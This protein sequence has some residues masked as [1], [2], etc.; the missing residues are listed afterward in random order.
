M[1]LFVHS[2]R[3][4]NQLIDINASYSPENQEK[5]MQIKKQI[6]YVLALLLIFLPATVMAATVTLNWQANQEADISGYNVY[7]GAA[8]R[9]YGQPIPAGNVTSYTVENLTEG[10]TYYFAV[11]AVDTSGNESG[12]SGEVT[13]NATS[14]E[15]ATENYQLLLST[16][17]NRSNAVKLDD[18]SISGNVYIYLD[19]EAYVSQVV[20]SIDG[21]THNT[22]N[23]APYDLGVPF[24]SSTLSN[25]S[26]T[27]S[28]L[29]RLQDGTNQSVSAVCTVQ[30]E[31]TV[32][33]P[34][35]NDTQTEV[36]VRWTSYS[37]RD[38]A[39]PIRIYDGTQL[40][41]TV[42]VNQKINGGKWNSIGSYTF[43]NSPKVDIVA[44]G[45]A[46]TVADAVRFSFPD[47]TTTIID[48]GKN[49]T[50][51]SG[52]WSPSGVKGYY[53]TVSVYTKFEGSY[54]FNVESTVTDP[55]PPPSTS[56]T[57]A[58]VFVWWTSHSNRD[59][60]VPIRIYDGTQLL[61]TVRVNQKIN[62]GKWN[63]VGSYTFSNRPKVDVVSRGTAIA[64]ADAVR[65]IFSDGTT[66]IVDNGKL[67]TSSSGKW[68]ASGVSK[69]YGTRSVY[70][71]STG[72]YTF[73]AN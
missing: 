32:P 27:I 12:Y 24:D 67:G 56:N 44:R 40:L 15:P 2:I 62:G 51:E 60:A 35:D 16:N 7:Y 50:S 46:V 66:T 36:F 22:E 9:S 73:N 3:E 70:N 72:T 26:H 13:A 59:S 61:G 58:E 47:G 31:S 29:V 64:V 37:N 49:G 17:S 71:R 53:G 43:S 54:S 45:A 34:T 33:P 42:R 57:E 38:S 20:F 25:G 18:Q 4:N 11:T 10:S 5:N 65:F 23:Y 69:F 68:S 21:Q 55:L 48:N 63:S 14:S 19:P 6:K 8:S 28:A 30:N 41:G 52:I 39:V 1:A